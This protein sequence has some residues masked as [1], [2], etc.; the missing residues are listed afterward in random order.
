MAEASY[1]TCQACIS[2]VGSFF[3][4]D[5]CPTLSQDVLAK[6]IRGRYI[7]ADP[8]IY[9]STCLISAN[10]MLGQKGPDGPQNTQH[11]KDD[12]QHTRDDPLPGR[13][14]VPEQL[15]VERDGEDDRD[16]GAQRSAEE[17]AHRVKGR[18]H[19][20]DG[21]QEEHH[22]DAHEGPDALG[23][24]GRGP[25]GM[26]VCVLVVVVVMVDAAEDVHGRDDGTGVEG[27]L[28]QGDD[29]DED[30]HDDAHALGV[31]CRLEDVGRD[32]VLDAI[33][34]HEQ[35]DD[36][37]A[38]VQDVLALV[39]KRGGGSIYGRGAMLIKTHRE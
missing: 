27:D 6:M 3:G 9:T 2:F 8:I 11:G 26:A 7:L 37:Q 22:K 10:E 23:D 33:A 15:E 34:K 20:G 36:G 38:S 21:E 17:G 25:G 4:I 29:G 24:Q 18:E 13:H 12:Q 19:D 14:V 28:G 16:E 5:K 1:S 30:A 35:A 32:G 39:R 31:S